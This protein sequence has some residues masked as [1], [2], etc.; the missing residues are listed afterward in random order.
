MLRIFTFLLSTWSQIL[1]YKKCRCLD[2]E[3]HKCPSTYCVFKIFIIF[4]INY[5]FLY[6]IYFRA[7]VWD[8]CVFPN[9]IFTKCPS[10]Y[11]HYFKFFIFEIRYD[12]KTPKTP[13]IPIFIKIVGIEENSQSRVG[14]SVPKMNH[15]LSPH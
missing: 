4:I 5:T 9:N 8:F 2:H 15:F 1:F 7:Y 12:I 11:I 3:I 6:F 10:F 13:R 14:K